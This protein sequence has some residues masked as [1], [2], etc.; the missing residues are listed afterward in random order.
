MLHDQ[1]VRRFCHKR[2]YS[3]LD[4]SVSYLMS[5]NP[6][7]TTNFCGIQCEFYTVRQCRV[8]LSS[9]LLVDFCS[10]KKT[11]HTDILISQPIIMSV[12]SFIPQEIIRLFFHLK[13]GKST[14]SGGSA[15]L[16][17]RARAIRTWHWS[18]RER[19]IHHQ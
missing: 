18:M 19:A 14:N 8:D 6:I 4:Q 3:Y 1:A 16:L 17:L 12:S 5:L 7:K 2:V 13:L 10:V 11:I 15:L 9:S